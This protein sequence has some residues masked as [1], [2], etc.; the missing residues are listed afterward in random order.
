M[1]REWESLAEA[2]GRYAVTGFAGN[3]QAWSKQGSRRRG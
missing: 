3:E 2:A 1:R